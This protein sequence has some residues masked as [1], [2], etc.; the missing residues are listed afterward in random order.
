MVRT[1]RLTCV[2][3][4]LAFRKHLSSLGDTWGATLLRNIG[5]PN[6][7][8]S[9]SLRASWRSRLCQRMCDCWAS[10]I[11][12]SSPFFS[13]S[14]RE[15]IIFFNFTLKYWVFF[16]IELCNFIQFAFFIFILGSRPDYGFCMLTQVDS[17]WFFLTF[18][19]QHLIC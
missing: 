1:N 13:L 14:L 3:H 2:T 6:R 8:R 9:I 5:F 11:F 18:F 15:K 10:M 19:F 7:F 4:T 12:F 17:G 16:I